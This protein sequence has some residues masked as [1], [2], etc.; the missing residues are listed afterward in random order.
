[1]AWSV[2]SCASR[3]LWDTT[4]VSGKSVRVIV[5]SSIPKVAKF[6]DLERY[7]ACF[8]RKQRQAIAHR[9][10]FERFGINAVLASKKPETWTARM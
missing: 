7:L 3:S 5:F 2:R 10:E 4:Q 9:F 8:C 6:G 1:M